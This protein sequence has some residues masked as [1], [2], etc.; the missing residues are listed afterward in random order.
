MRYDA[1]RLDLS[2]GAKVSLWNNLGGDYSNLIQADV[3]KQP[4]YMIDGLNGKPTVKLENSFLESVLEL[5]EKENGTMFLVM[6]ADTIPKSSTVFNLGKDIY[7]HGFGV[8][9]SSS[10]QKPAFL[11][12]T[13]STSNAARVEANGTGTAYVIAAAYNGVNIESFADGVKATHSLPAGQQGDLVDLNRVMM[14]NVNHNPAV[15]TSED[16]D[17]RISEVI[18]FSRLLTESEISEVNT[19][20]MNKWS[21]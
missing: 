20:L 10:Q 3:A 2:D 21:I 1:S 6:Q 4:V 9:M 7:Y 15:N 8:R 14:G 13:P 16:M 12:N 5:D 11:V 17:G 19:Y 18:Y